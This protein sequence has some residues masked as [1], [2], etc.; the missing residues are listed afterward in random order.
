MV[1][2]INP[3]VPNVQPALVYFTKQ[4]AGCTEK[5]FEF[6]L[7]A[8]KDF[9]KKH[10]DGKDYIIIPFGTPYQRSNN[11]IEIISGWEKPDGW[12]IYVSASDA[13]LINNLPRHHVYENKK[14]NIVAGLRTPDLWSKRPSAKPKKIQAN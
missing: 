12:Y 4:P 14:F 13:R 7:E 9:A 5:D 3:A 8:A 11:Q 1:D 6:V 10:Y 2:G